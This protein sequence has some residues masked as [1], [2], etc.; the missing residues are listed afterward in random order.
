MTNF[1]TRRI[2][3]SAVAALAMTAT[4]ANALED[5][6]NGQV[7]EVE[8][9]D[10]IALSGGGEV[11]VRYG[12]SASIRIIEGAE[13]LKL[14]FRNSSVK[15]E[16]VWRCP[17]NSRRRLEVTMPEVEDIAVTGGGTMT[18]EEGFPEQR[19]LNAAVTGGGTLKAYALS[20]REVNAAVTGGGTVEVSTDGELNA[21]V[22]GGGTVRYDGDPSINATTMGGGSIR[23]R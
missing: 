21:A 16:C 22:T 6:T 17:R 7:I 4:G 1:M 14:T 15:I 13:S 23:S 19:E 12:E 5:Y 9:L 10:G 20:A 8:R 2:A 11:T 3:I 18:I